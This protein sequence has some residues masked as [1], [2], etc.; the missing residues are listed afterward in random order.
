MGWKELPAFFCGTTETARD[1]VA[2]MAG[3]EA[4]GAD[5]LP[6]HSL[7]HKVM[8]P[9]AMLA[10]PADP[11][12]DPYPW[13][14]IE[15]FI[16]DFIL[17]LSKVSHFR[18]LSRVALHGIHSVFPL[19]SVTGNKDGK[20]PVLL[21][22]LRQGDGDW[23]TKKVILGWLLDGVARQVSLSLDKT[24]SYRADL[25]SLLG[26]QKK[27]RVKLKQF[28]RVVGKLHFAAIAIPAGNGL[29]L[30]LNRAMRGKPKFV[31]IRRK[32]ETREALE[33][34]LAL[35]DDVARHPTHMFELCL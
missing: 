23:T 21:K 27:Q 11:T 28:Q 18:R 25:K 8:F 26:S 19:P 2:M 13:V 5:D 33:D 24:K 3:V 20:E 29:F 32:S 17:M 34:W 16:D 9:E 31:G 10:P 14:N 15:S 30:L 7:E 4:P 6:E 22:K 12:A 35:L 1:V